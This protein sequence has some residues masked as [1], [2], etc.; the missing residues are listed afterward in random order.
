MAGTMIEFC[1]SW[2]ESYFKGTQD[3]D[4]LAAFENEFYKGVVVSDLSLDVV[5]HGLLIILNQKGK[6]YI[7]QSI[8]IT[9]FNVIETE[10]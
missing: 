1:L 8:L 10:S 5:F 6:I 7:T 4:V 3:I 2:T 9:L